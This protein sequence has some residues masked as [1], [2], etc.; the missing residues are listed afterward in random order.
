MLRFFK[1]SAFQARSS[2]QGQEA[3]WRQQTLLCGSAVVYQG[4]YGPWKVEPEDIAEVMSYRAGLTVTVAAF[5][6]LSL[7]TT[8]ATSTGPADAADVAALAALNPLSLL[9]CAAL[10]LSLIQIHIYV[11]EIK[12][13]IQ[14]LWLLG[15]I[16]GSY[17]VLTHPEQPLPLLVA[18]NAWATF[19]VGPVA[20]AVTGVAIKE[21]L[22][23]GKPEAA[24]LAVLLPF[25]CLCHLVGAG[26]ELQQGLV[27]AV[28]ATA[29][30]F[31]ARKYSQPVKDD[32]GDKSVFMFRKLT[33]EQQE[34]ILGQQLQQ[35]FVEQ[36]DKEA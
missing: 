4:V 18:E 20:A 23:Y 27:A 30:V 11:T 36:A 9:G 19:L 8:K 25:L 32:I 12:R 24:A 3:T 1:S 29:A 6:T 21:G 10:G 31:A 16:G 2:A 34:A 7:L 26:A 15:V 14:G 5:I 17:L 13:A 28:C 22:C 35:Q 33:P